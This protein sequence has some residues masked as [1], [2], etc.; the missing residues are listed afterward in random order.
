MYRAALQEQPI[1]RTGLTVAAL[2]G[3]YLDHARSY[4]VRQD[5]QP[6]GQYAVIRAAMQR[7]IAAYPRLDADGLE[8]GHLL[9]WRE[10]LIAELARTTV[11]TYAERARWAYR[12]AAQRGLVPAST[13][14]ALTAVQ[15]LTRLRG[16]SEAHPVGPVADDIVDATLPH[17]SPVVADMVRLHRLT[18]MRSDELTAMRAQDIDRGGKVWMYQPAQHKTA[19]Q[20]QPRVVPL[21][22]KAQ[23]IL[24]RYLGNAP[25]LF[26]PRAVR[27]SAGPRYTP[28][29]Y[30]QAVRYGIAAAG[31]EPWTP[32]QLRHSAATRIFEEAD[33]DT[34]GGM[35]GHATEAMTRRYARTAL[36]RMRLAK[37]IAAARERG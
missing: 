7:L 22:P 9:S 17:L 14:T 13:W 32:H 4:Y 8:P 20:D 3:K 28:S 26:S 30:R 12:W 2:A 11:N 6:T 18:G 10:G 24:K 16:G 34:A 27:A 31:V 37:A 19:H 25:F 15:P 36:E 23:K 21:G 33:L 5:G 35:L 1:Q 29:T